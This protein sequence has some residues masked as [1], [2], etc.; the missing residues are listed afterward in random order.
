MVLNPLGPGALRTGAPQR[1]QKNAYD[2]WFPGP[3]RPLE[4][5]DHWA[6]IIG[7]ATQVRA[8]G[9]YAGS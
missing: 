2:R 7:R 5:D 8:S 3:G 1:A 4:D 9:W 6:Y